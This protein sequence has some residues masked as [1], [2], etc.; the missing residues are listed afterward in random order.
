MKP[1]I[2]LALL[3]LVPLAVFL[4]VARERRANWKGKS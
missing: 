3:L 2:T 1:L 4:G